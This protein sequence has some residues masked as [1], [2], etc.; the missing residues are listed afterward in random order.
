MLKASRSGYV[1]TKLEEITT[2]DLRL[3]LVGDTAALRE[4]SHD[5]HP[6][7]A[8][9]TQLQFIPDSVHLA[10]DVTQRNVSRQRR[11]HRARDV[12]DFFTAGK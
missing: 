11:F 7:S 5:Q 1:F 3:R 4:S 6:C 12:A 8:G 10:A 2:L 9:R